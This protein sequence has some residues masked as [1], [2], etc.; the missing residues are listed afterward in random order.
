MKVGM[1]PTLAT[2]RPPPTWV[3]PYRPSRVAGAAVALG[4]LGCELAAEAPRAVAE[5]ALVTEVRAA[6]P[7]I[8]SPAAPE[9]QP[10]AP[11]ASGACADVA[12]Q[13]RELGRSLPRR[14]DDDTVATAVTSSGCD[15]R[16]EYELP[17]L[18]AADVS[19]AGLRAMRARVL[20]QLCSDPGALAVMHRGGRFTN[21]YFDRARTQIALFS[22][23]A[24]DCGI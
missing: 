12:R 22:V 5:R 9:A 2:R 21:V 14:L 13:A 16:L 20:T 18:D 7:A 23:A 11:R 8:P 24:D 6:L 1:G 4:A 3:E 19:A 15:L 17:T 10:A